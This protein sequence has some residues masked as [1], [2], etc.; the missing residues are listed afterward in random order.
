VATR[1]AV[2]GKGG[3]G[4]T[5]FAA[6]LIRAA[7]PR[8]KPRKELLLAV[9][10]DPDTNLPAALGVQVRRTVG[11]MRERMMKERDSLPPD[12]SK[13]R[14]LESWVFETLHEGDGYD[15]LVMGRPE[16]PGCYCYANN[17]LASI[18]QRLVGNYAVT[19]IDTAAG[20]EHI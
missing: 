10:A 5:A 19:V 15:L 9:D 3:T 17:M 7:L 12:T 13:E 11:D 1:I 20:L 14:A 8:L 4:K 18:V 16:G 6:L 2:T